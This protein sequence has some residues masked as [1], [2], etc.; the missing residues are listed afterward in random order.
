MHACNMS[1]ALALD[2]TCSLAYYNRAVCYRLW[3]KPS[4]AID[5]YSR[6]IAMQPMSNPVVYLN[7]G[8]LLFEKKV[9]A[10]VIL[11]AYGP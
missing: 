9:I 11:W 3:G 6:I 8:L 7:R 5:D 10:S 2:N 1:Q 4:K